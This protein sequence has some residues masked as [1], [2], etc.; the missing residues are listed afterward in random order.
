MHYI[1]F[2]VLFSNSFVKLSEESVCVSESS[3]H[4]GSRDCRNDSWIIFL[5]IYRHSD[6][7]RLYLSEICRQQVSDP[8]IKSHWTEWMK[9][10]WCFSL[11]VSQSFWLCSR[12][13][14]CPEYDDSHSSTDSLQ[15]CDLSEDTTGAGGGKHNIYILN[16]LFFPWIPQ[17]YVLL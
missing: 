1:I 15:L 4:L 13:H 7:W 16:N 14:V 6:S 11:S 3:V 2:F 8:V 9:H 17:Y 12:G 5:G 10:C